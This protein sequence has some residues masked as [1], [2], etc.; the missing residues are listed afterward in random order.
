[1]KKPYL[2]QR[3]KLSRNKTQGIKSF[4]DYFDCDYMGSAEFEFGALPKSLK[5]FTKT[6]DLKSTKFDT[7]NSEDKHLYIVSAE[8]N[9]RSKEYY[10]LY[11]KELQDNDFPFHT[12]ESTY[13]KSN[14]NGKTK[15]FTKVDVWW[16]I[17]NNIMF[18][19]GKSTKDAILKAIRNTRLKKQLAKEDT[20][21]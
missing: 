20:W 10:E 9:E 5:T 2:I 1:M 12:K 4:N 11:F 3:V 18:C 14:I 16:D 8:N 15:H 6:S 7:K 13:L 19:F 21:Y 17:E